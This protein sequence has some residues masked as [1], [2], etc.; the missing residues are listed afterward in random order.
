V[1][2]VRSYSLYFPD[3]QGVT[4]FEMFK[5][6][7]WEDRAERRAFPVEM[8]VSSRRC[9]FLRTLL[10]QPVWIAGKVG[11]ASRIVPVL[12]ASVLLPPLSGFQQPL[13][14]TAHLRI[15]SQ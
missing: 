7:L 6:T 14:A 4:A 2:A 3:R 13:P 11:G 1:R 9:S 15:L 10:V 12:D 5:E 8:V